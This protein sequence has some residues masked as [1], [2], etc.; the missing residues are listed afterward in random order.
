MG[1]SPVF[2][3]PLFWMQPMLVRAAVE[4]IPQWMREC[5]GLTGHHGL[6]SWEP[7]LVKRAGAVSDRIVLAQSPATQSCLRLGLP[8]TYLY[9]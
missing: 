2:P 5:L 4:M 6:R 3:R 7:W 1:A 8:A 9:S